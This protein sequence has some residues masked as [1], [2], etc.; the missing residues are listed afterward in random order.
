MQSWTAVLGVSWPDAWLRTAWLGCFAGESQQPVCPAL[1]CEAVWPQTIGQFLT[2]CWLL[3]AL[4]FKGLSPLAAFLLL[5][6]L[7]AFP[8]TV[9]QQKY[10]A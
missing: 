2:G 6:A 3:F 7:Q 8:V 9:N 4:F 5:C 10:R 1:P